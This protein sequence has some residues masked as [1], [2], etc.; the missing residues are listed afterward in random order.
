MSVAMRV[1]SVA[2][3]V[4]VA[5]WSLSVIIELSINYDI[6]TAKSVFTFL[7]GK[8]V[9]YQFASAEK[10]FA[11]SAILF[12]SYNFSYLLHYGSALAALIVLFMSFATFAVNGSDVNDVNLNILIWD[13]F[14]LMV[15]YILTCT[16][17]EPLEFL[18]NGRSTFSRTK[19]AMYI[20]TLMLSLL[21]ASYI[22]GVSIHEN[23]N[24]NVISVGGI[25]DPL[26]WRFITVFV[27]ICGIFV[28]NLLVSFF[29]YV[30]PSSRLLYIPSFFLSAIVV[31]MNF[32]FVAI[33]WGLYL[34]VLFLYGQVPDALRRTG[35]P[36]RCEI[37]LCGFN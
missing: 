32:C 6:Q 25:W 12:V 27:Y 5:I 3:A 2:C 23:I 18:W 20:F 28:S 1:F 33:G 35:L 9:V 29:F 17:G 21:S 36:V 10:L 19:N 22:A 26:S 16:N 7:L 31:A 13:V 37:F 24:D 4:S 14:Y 34:V 15:F 30:Y 11:L 8:S